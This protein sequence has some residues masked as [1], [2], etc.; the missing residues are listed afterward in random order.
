MSREAI[1]TKVML[2]Q[3]SSGLK[4]MDKANKILDQVTSELVSELPEH[5]RAEASSLLSR[6]KKGKIDISELMTFAKDIKQEEKEGMKKSAEKV[7]S[8][9][10][11]IKKK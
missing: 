1:N 4:E 3:L 10:E 7:V 2:E 6:A 9:A 11:S 8:K 5:K